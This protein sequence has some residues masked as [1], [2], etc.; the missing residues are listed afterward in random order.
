MLL[1]LRTVSSGIAARGNQISP[2]ALIYPQT[3]G[4]SNISFLR[5]S[6]SSCGELRD[7]VDFFFFPSAKGGGHP[8]SVQMTRITNKAVDGMELVQPLPIEPILSPC[9]PSFCVFRCCLLDIHTQSYRIRQDPGVRSWLQHAS[10]S[11][12]F[13]SC[14][15]LLRLVDGSVFVFSISEFVASPA[16]PCG[17]SFHLLFLHFLPSKERFH[18][19]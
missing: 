17:A 11:P 8:P 14:Y 16:S 3:P 18:V 2:R 7:C 13:L 5:C 19:L 9:A 12:L 4:T 1:Q 15:A 10:P 6:R